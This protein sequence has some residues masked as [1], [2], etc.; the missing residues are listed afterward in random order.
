MNRV[1][2]TLVVLAASNARC[3]PAR[4]ERQ[5][6]Q[7]ARIQSS[8]MTQTTLQLSDGNFVIIT[9]EDARN[10]RTAVEHYLAT[11]KPKLEQPVP[12]PGDPVST[13]TQFPPGVII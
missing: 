8:C 9:L 2:L 1:L 13:I 11:G 10:I 7:P 6:V 3:S 5:A 12:P 4:S